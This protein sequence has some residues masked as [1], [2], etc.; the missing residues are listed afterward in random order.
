MSNPMPSD[1]KQL[2]H[3][4][5]WATP[6]ILKLFPTIQTAVRANPVLLNMFSLLLIFGFFRAP[7]TGIFTT[8]VPKDNSR[9]QP[10]LFGEVG[11]RAEQVPKRAPSCSNAR[12]VGFHKAIRAAL[13]AKRNMRPQGDALKHGHC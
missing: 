12:S 3:S 11:A 2:K 13:S 9:I 5:I 6:N 10:L 7:G 1:Q 4:L 8:R